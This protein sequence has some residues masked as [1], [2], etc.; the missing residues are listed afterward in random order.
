MKEEEEWE[1]DWAE[2]LLFSGAYGAAA[3]V[4]VVQQGVVGS[5]C[6]VCCW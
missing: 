6:C 5:L 1:H 3:V 2:T 4:S